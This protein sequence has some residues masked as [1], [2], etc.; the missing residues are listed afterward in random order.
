MSEH[1]VLLHTIPL[2]ILWYC[3]YALSRSRTSGSMAADAAQASCGPPQS[4]SRMMSMAV[5][6]DG[7]RLASAL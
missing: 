1:S 3:P 4:T 5:S 6:R 7:G 2:T